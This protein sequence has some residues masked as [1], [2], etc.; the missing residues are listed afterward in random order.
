MEPE[1]IEKREFLISLRGYDRDEVDSFLRELADEIRSLKKESSAAQ[2]ASGPAESQTN[3]D[4]AAAL[5]GVGEETS[6]ILLAA[7]EAAD[8]IRQRARR[9]AAEILT[10]ARQEAD[11]V[12]RE[13]Q[14]QRQEHEED[15][16][17]LREARNILATQLEDVRRRLDETIGRL[18]AP[19]DS[20]TQ[21]RTARPERVP[22]EKTVRKA[23]SSRREAEKKPQ[24]PETKAPPPELRVVEKEPEIIPEEPQPPANKLESPAVAEPLVTQE[25]PED[26][27]SIKSLLSEIRREREEGRQAVEEALAVETSLPT[28]DDP[29]GRRSSALGDATEQ[30]SRRMKRLLQE[31]QND[32]LDRL[33]RQRG[34]GTVAENLIPEDEHLG[35][36]R[37]GLIDVLGS[38]F[39]EGRKAGGSTDEKDPKA[40]IGAL[41]GKQLVNPLRNELSRAVEAGLEAR[42]TPTAISE[43][44][45]DIF[46]VWKGVRTELLGEGMVYAAYHQGLIDVWTSHGA[47]TKAWVISPDEKECPKDVCKQN[48]AAG[49][50]ALNAPFPSGHNAPPAHGGCTCTITGP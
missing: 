48:A 34:K 20:A 31:D 42:D 21:I 22:T 40:A 16:R 14:T 43:R 27:S 23:E 49:E 6:K 41:V 4:R 39:V 38:A 44:A 50:V 13:A 30:A 19:I 26:E 36:F 5:K 8:E 3:F 25:E 45:S 17:R 9:E 10:D 32:L 2:P 33:R 46:R 24:Q 15:F 29:L 12:A 47:A 28:G 7:E 18:Q 37:D 1:D 11:R 35:R